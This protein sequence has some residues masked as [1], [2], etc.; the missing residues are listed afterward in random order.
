MPGDAAHERH[1][2][3]DGDDGERDGNHGQANLVGG[4]ERRAIRR[5]SPTHVAYD[6]LDLDDGVVDEN[7]GH[8]RDTEKG[9]E[10][11]RKAHDGHRPKCWDRRQG[12]RD[13]GNQSCAD[14]S[15]EEQHHKDCEDGAFDQCLH[16]GVIVAERIGHGIIDFGEVYFGVLRPQLVKVCFH[17]LGNGKLTLSLGAEHGKCHYGLA[18]EAS[19]RALLA[20]IIDDA[21]EVFEPNL[22]P[23]RDNDLGL[24]QIL[25]AVRTR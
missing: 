12:E 9:D 20:G 14:I 13:R 15:Q 25:Y 17:H 18:I 22:A 3:E 21:A 7:A 19:K 11:E 8:E 5:F 10:I 1:R 24:G 2:C 16:R 6:V 23:A 4:L